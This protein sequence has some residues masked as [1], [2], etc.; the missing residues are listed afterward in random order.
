M[1][2]FFNSKYAKLT[3]YTPGE[4]PQD[5]QYTKLNTNES[6]FPVS[7]KAVKYVSEAA[8]KLQLYPDPECRQL[9]QKIADYYGVGF[10]NVLLTNGSDEILNFAF[11]AFCEKGAAFPDITYGFYS[12]FAELNGVEYTEF[13]L[14]DDFTVKLDD[15]INTDKTV[16]IAN[17]NAPTGIALKLEEIEKI[18]RSKPNRLV[19]VDEAYVDFGADSAVNLTKKYDNLLV[20][21]TF[22][23]SRSL[24]GGR[25]GYGIGN[26]DLICDLNTIKY[27]T[28]PYNI[29]RLSAAA[30]LGMIEDDEYVRENCQKII[31]NRTYTEKK[32]AELGFTFTNSLANFIFAK[33]PLVSGKEIYL[34]LKK[35]GVL[36]RH[37]D[38]ERLTE[39]NRITVGTK[40][41]MDILVKTLKEILEEKI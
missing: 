30:G 4:Q 16:F 12:V 18:L 17:P 29:N 36:V 23:K 32:L 7:A 5:M 1:S 11:M 31:D 25:L 20:I 40:E 39:Y 38:K 26:K 35:R 28:N 22:S 6:P 19:I 2:K 37:F 14:N 27:S 9:T 41:Q 15:Y 33:H 3:P 10:E 8:E 13:P 21:H 34:E 24:A